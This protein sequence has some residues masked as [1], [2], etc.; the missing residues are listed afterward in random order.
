MCSDHAIKTGN[1]REDPH[2]CCPTLLQLPSFL[3]RAPLPSVESPARLASQ[4]K[5]KLCPGTWHDTNQNTKVLLMRNAAPSA[6][7]GHW[8]TCCDAVSAVRKKACNEE[9]IT[10]L[11]R[12]RSQPLRAD[13]TNRLLY[14][15]MALLIVASS[16]SFCRNCS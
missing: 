9:R 11:R 5:T 2:A 4:T 3:R 10:W 12:T 1:L 8:H 16:S 7:S 6:D 13:C 15:D 14:K